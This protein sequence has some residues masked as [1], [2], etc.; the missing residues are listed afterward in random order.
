MA[1]LLKKQVIQI[2]LNALRRSTTQQ[3]EKTAL[4]VTGKAAV[5]SAATSTTTASA[6]AATATAEPKVN[7]LNRFKNYL[8]TIYLDYKDVV[9]HTGK[10]AGEKPFKALAYGLLMSAMLV[11][12]KKNPDLRDY[13]NIRKELCNDLLMCGTTHSKRSHFYLNELNRLDNLEQLEYKSCVFFSLIMVK[14]FSAHEATYEKNCTQLNSPNKFNIFNA[15]NTALK[16]VSR[17]IDIGFLDEWYFLSKN[18]KDY[19]VNELEWNKKQKT[20]A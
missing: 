3:A 17:I 15:P 9:V 5:E 16:L 7:F 19:D 13:Q 1:G 2:N 14:K 18:M 10:Q 8:K 6:S 20:H 4:N 12:Y 11:S